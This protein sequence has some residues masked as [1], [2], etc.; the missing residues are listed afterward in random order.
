[1]FKDP[2]VVAAVIT[3]VGMLATFVF[4]LIFNGCQRKEDSKER[5]FYEIYQRR[6]ALYDD[7]CK[8]LTDMGRPKEELLHM[9]VREF[10]NKV[11][12]DSHTLVALTNRLSIYGSPA[13]RQIL[14]APILEM[15]EILRKNILVHFANISGSEIVNSAVNSA[16]FANVLDSFILLVNKSLLEFS[17]SVGKET[18]ADFVDKEITEF[19]GRVSVKK[20]KNKPNKRNSAE[21]DKGVGD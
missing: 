11:I 15:N 7:V 19:L 2:V 3:V 5:F 18:G 8:T 14:N 1:M 13:A 16:L 10:G 12:G 9:S 6:L 4:T 17:E 20:K 21:P